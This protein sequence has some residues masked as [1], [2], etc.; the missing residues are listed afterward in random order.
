MRLGSITL[1]AT[2]LSAALA[3]AG[4]GGEPTDAVAVTSA[5]TLEGDSAL[6]ASA[7]AASDAIG[8]CVKPAEAQIE[9]KVVGLQSGAIIM[10]GCSQNGTENTHRL[11]AV[12]DSD[13]L[14]LLPLPD[15]SAEGWFATTQASMAELDAGN[16]MLT[17]FRKSAEDGSCGAEGSYHW[18]GKRFVLQELRWQDCTAPDRKGPPFPV[19]WPTQVG[20]V[21]DPNGATPEP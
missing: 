8:G 15:Y 18:D 19:V 10:L 17:T 6:I 21:V 7:Q 1:M 16:E 12:K 5:G 11:F 14:E 4:C 9:S 2:G 20:A 13:V 3:L